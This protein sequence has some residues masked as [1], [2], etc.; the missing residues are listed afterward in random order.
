MMA[1]LTEVEQDDFTA[2]LHSAIVA[3]LPDWEPERRDVHVQPAI[4]NGEPMQ[5]DTL[6]AVNSRSS[7]AATRAATDSGSESTL[8][9][10]PNTLM[11]PIAA[12]TAPNSPQKLRPETDENFEDG[13]DETLI[14]GGYDEPIVTD[15]QNTGAATLLPDQSGGRTPA[16]KDQ[17]LSGGFSYTTLA[18]NS[19]RLGIEES[20]VI[21]R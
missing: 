1:A 14:F 19:T 4:E 18:Y 8:P 20:T 7:N 21:P 6:L 11:S 13:D 5:E 12:T 15:H 17:G 3:A 9:S 2:Q 16:T 10:S